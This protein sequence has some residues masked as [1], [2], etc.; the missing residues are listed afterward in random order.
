MNGHKVLVRVY[1]VGTEKMLDRDAEIRQQ[2]QLSRRGLTAKFFAKFRNG[3]CYEYLEG[4]PLDATNVGL[5][6]KAIGH[7]L[8]KWHRVTDIHD[9]SETSESSAIVLVRKWLK[10]LPHTLPVWKRSHYNSLGI[11]QE[12]ESLLPRLIESPLRFCH[13]DVLPFNILLDHEGKAK[14]I[15]YE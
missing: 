4:T 8:G 15:D 6:V 14:F 11:C 2:I 7:E 10:L 3:C 12:F 5:H 9:E 1:G 13:N